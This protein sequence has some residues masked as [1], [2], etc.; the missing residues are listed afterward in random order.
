MKDA[1][2]TLPSLPPKDKDVARSGWSSSSPS[3]QP[4]S[5]AAQSPQSQD[6]LELWKRR[7]AKTDKHIEVSELRLRSSHG[8]T[9]A[10]ELPVP[11]PKEERPEPPSKSQFL[12]TGSS[13][14][15]AA[16]QLSPGPLPTDLNSKRLPPRSPGGGLPGRNIRPNPSAETLTRNEDITMG[17]ALSKAEAKLKHRRPGDGEQPTVNGSADVAKP[18][19]DDDDT[20]RWQQPQA[21]SNPPAAKSPVAVQ[22][23]STIRR[24]P[25][26][27]Y[28][29]HDIRSPGIEQVASPVSPVSPASSPDL[30]PHQPVPRKPLP[31]AVIPTEAA[32]VQRKGVPEPASTA[33]PASSNGE[34]DKMGGIFSSISKSPDARLKPKPSNATLAEQAVPS[35]SAAAP[36]AAPTGLGV[37]QP[38]QPHYR[39]LLSPT[40]D[41]T[42]T[43]GGQ[44]Q[45]PTRTSSRGAEMPTSPTMRGAAEQPAVALDTESVSESIAEA[46]FSA[47]NSPTTLKAQPVPVS[48]QPAPPPP[49]QQQHQQQQYQQPSQDFRSSDG[50]IFKE[51]VQT[52]D[53]DPAAARF[54]SMAAAIGPAPAAG[55]VFQ[56]R[57]LKPSHW[58]CVHKHRFMAPTPNSNYPLACQTCARED[59]E[60]RFRC[61]FCWLRVC[62]PCKEVLFQNKGDLGALVARIKEAGGQPVPS[63]MSVQKYGGAVPN[64]MPGSP[65]VIAPM[66]PQAAY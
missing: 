38:L 42:P 48:S 22:H 31:S 64:G 19:P 59:A 57:G 3:Q 27:D 16:Q 60:D 1:G 44:A 35:A 49:P 36:P 50:T 7:S 54:P 58:G 40:V 62:V 51:L 41:V 26:P 33:P 14:L 46:Y 5:T 56:M 43:N 34:P 17:S 15:A 66:S 11:P 12:Q 45:F 9:A 55:T 23:P 8:S 39:S 61:R 37:N 13:S 47:P 21:P 6:E 24:L 25:T 30:V 2:R 18:R 28:E 4:T 32:V 63:T 53:F 10:S 52:D 65:V 29:Q 20:S